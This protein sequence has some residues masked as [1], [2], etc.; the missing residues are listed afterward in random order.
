MAYKDKEVQKEY[1]RK[2]YLKNGRNR[3]EGYELEIEKWRKVN[4]KKAAA[5]SVVARAVR[6]GRL[7]KPK[8][9]SKCGR[10]TRLSGHHPDYKKPLEVVW[11]CSSCHKL[12]HPC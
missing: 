12:E 7:V 1:Y 4:P 6:S 9:C 3:A 5:R 2:W 8:K 11:L 10:A